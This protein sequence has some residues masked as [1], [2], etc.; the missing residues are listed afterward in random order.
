M[1]LYLSIDLV[2]EWDNGV[3]GPVLGRDKEN[4][5]PLDVYPI[6]TGRL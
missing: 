1:E 2:V 6:Q 3:G 4:P 5:L